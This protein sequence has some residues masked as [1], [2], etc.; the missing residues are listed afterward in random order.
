MKHP[1]A[2]G[3]VDKEWDTLKNLSAWDFQKVNPGS[4]SEEGRKISI[5]IPHGPSTISN[6]PSFGNISKNTKGTVVLRG[7]GVKDHSS[8]RALFTEEGASASEMEAAT[9]LALSRLRGMAGAAQCKLKRRCTCPKHRD[10]CDC[11][12][13]VHMCGSD[14]H[15]VADG[16]HGTPVRNQWFAMSEAYTVTH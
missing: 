13:S 8:Y 16:S 7:D 6:T 15:P 10:Y 4:T 9:F 2:K 3:A 12:R 11:Q 1:E 5:R 14:C